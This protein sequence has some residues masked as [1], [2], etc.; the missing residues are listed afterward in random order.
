MHFFLVEGFLFKKECTT[1]VAL[2]ITDD[3]KSANNI[4]INGFYYFWSFNFSV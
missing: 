2:E 1:F 4:F 3:S